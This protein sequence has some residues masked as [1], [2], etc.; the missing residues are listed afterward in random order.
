[1][2]LVTAAIW[3]LILTPLFLLVVSA[4]V[5]GAKGPLSLLLVMISTMVWLGVGATTFELWRRK[6]SRMSLA[7]LL[8]GWAGILSPAVLFMSGRYFYIDDGDSSIFPPALLAA[9]WM[10]L[11]GFLVPALRRSNLFRHN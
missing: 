2:A 4:L 3:A 9:A 5:L 10:I 6:S 7:A 8:M 1:M 11:A